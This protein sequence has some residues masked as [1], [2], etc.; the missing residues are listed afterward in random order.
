MRD[1]MQTF[2]SVEEVAIYILFDGVF[3]T[4]GTSRGRLDAPTP[5]VASVD[6]D[7]G[8][9]I[10]SVWLLSKEGG[11]GAAEGRGGGYGEMDMLVTEAEWAW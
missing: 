11:S 1:W 3:G 8:L 2:P 6:R 9:E 7:S 4:A 10:E 5:T